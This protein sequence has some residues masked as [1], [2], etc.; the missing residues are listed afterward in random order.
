MEV[1]YPPKLHI[2]HQIHW[3]RRRGRQLLLYAE[4]YKVV[5]HSKYIPESDLSMIKEKIDKSLA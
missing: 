4:V 2:I 1:Q 3:Y 5:A